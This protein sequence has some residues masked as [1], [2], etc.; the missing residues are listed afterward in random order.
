M[1]SSLNAFDTGIREIVCSPI[2]IESVN[3]HRAFH[4]GGRCTRSDFAQLASARGSGQGRS[5]R[6]AILVSVRFRVLGP[7]EIETNGRLWPL[8]RRHERCLLGVL[9][10]ELG[11][12]VPADR[13]TQL[14]WESDP[15]QRAHRTVHSYVARI[16][17]R[18]AE[19]GAED[20]G[21]ALVSHAGGYVIR[22][23]SDRVDAYRFRSLVAEAL[24]TADL[25]ARDGLLRQALGLWRGDL[26]QG[27]AS[28]RLR[29]RLCADL[30]ELRAHT[31]EEAMVTGLALG[32]YRETIPE[33][34][35]L[36]AAEPTRERLVEL[37]MRS[38]YRVGRT[39]EALAAFERARAQMADRLGLDPGP[40]LTAVHVAI[41]RGEPL[42][43]DNRDGPPTGPQSP[44]GEMPQRTTAVPRGLPRDIADFTGRQEV[45]GQVLAAVPTDAAA[46]SA[47]V[48]IDGMAGVGKTA[49]AVN[50]AHRVADRYPDGQVALDLYGHSAHAPLEP[51]AAM[52][53]LL[54]QVGVP[55]DRIPVGLQERTVLW[56]SELAGRRMMLLLDNAAT[57]HQV[58]PLLP[59]GA[60]CLT[61]ITSRRRLAGLHGVR[62]FA[63]D[64]LPAD[65]AAALF[66]RAAGASDVDG[67]AAA[68]V[69]SRCGYLA[70]AIRLAAAR[71]VSRPNWTVQDLAARLGDA[72][73]AVREI[74]VEGRSLMAAFALSYEQLP[75]PGQ[76]MFRLL[77][78]VTGP[79]VDLRA[80]ASLIDL[81]ID[82]TDELLDDLADAHL[83]EEAVTGRYRMHDLLKQYA[84]TLAVA[85]DPEP[86]R[87][88][89]LGR[90]VDFY[91]HSAAAATGAFEPERSRF[92]YDLGEPPECA[93]LR[94]PTVDAA[95]AWY[96]TER[97]NLRAAIQ[98]AFDNG[99]HSRTWLL[100]RAIWF[101]L[102]GFGYHDDALANLSLVVR[103]AQRTGDSVA[104]ALAHNYLAGTNYRLARYREAFTQI[105]RA[106][107]IRMD[108]GDQLGAAASMMNRGRILVHLGRYA[109]ALDAFERALTIRLEAGAPPP[110]IGDN[111]LNIGLARMG[112]GDYAAAEEGY[113]RALRIAEDAGSDI[114]RAEACAHLG[115][116]E[117]LRGRHQ[118][119]IALLEH[120]RKEDFAGH[121]VLSADCVCD[122][123]SAYRGLGQVDQALRR[124]LEA[125]ATMKEGGSLYGECVVL[126]ELGVTLYEAGDR[127]GALERLRAALDI[128][129][130]LQLPVQQAHA[131]DGLA[132]VLAD[133]HPAAAADLSVRATAMFKELAIPRRGEDAG[134]VG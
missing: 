12:V 46:A 116:L 36:T 32:R 23:A 59:T 94:Y 77:G 42:G 26:L 132:T 70:L 19:A 40:R 101:F 11:R 13:L 56:R 114:S 121:L 14:L 99:W 8:A 22:A 126:I 123:G 31:V 44:E 80:A 89:A 86:E 37:H 111:Y 75:P 58:E 81:P 7:V 110:A 92:S 85:T 34:A 35:R 72:R 129:E 10:L 63:L 96:R 106:I 6:A 117:C 120:L 102:N 66:S 20:H 128:A 95:V 90:L 27:A 60:G 87:G 88:A 45:L 28:D 93:I 38:L 109:Q 83:I 48:A 76:R 71:L 115:K 103:S 73:P 51:A 131:L 53:I 133:T 2:A 130:R 17:A 68:E 82:A 125:L 127:D 52:D 62:F 98:V 122:L 91:L 74:A 119:A 21:V 69:V 113:R 25:T 3:V 49:L 39:A 104:L 78:L 84:A 50:A 55:G 5:L 64:V 118:A 41:L 43:V 16:R 79:D 108:I 134:L 47:V 15:P 100:S 105:D 97:A 61:L 9:L 4:A 24:S 33:L 54:R 30:D 65:E 124:H 1:I 29:Q 107:E 57:S 18:L 67:P 112:V